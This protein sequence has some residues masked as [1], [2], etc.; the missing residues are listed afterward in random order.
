[1]DNA[2]LVMECW[3]A[4][5]VRANTRSG[6]PGDVWSAWEQ[7]AKRL[8]AAVPEPGWERVVDAKD[9]QKGYVYASWW[10]APHDPME[11]LKTHARVAEEIARGM[12]VYRLRALNP[13]GTLPTP[14]ERSER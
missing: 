14:P 6:P 7:I 3:L 9:A 11:L 8:R 13:D 2:I 4:T 10:G 5:S 12:N 1:M